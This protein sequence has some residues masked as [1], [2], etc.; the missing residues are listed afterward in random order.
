MP[1]LFHLEIELPNPG[2]VSLGGGARPYWYGGQFDVLERFL[3]QCPDT[4]FIGHA[5]GFWREM[6]GDSDVREIY[7]RGPVQP[8]G[9]LRDLLDRFPNLH[10]DL[11]A[12]S[13][14]NALSRDP[15]NARDFLTTYS[16][17]VLFGRDY[18]DDRLRPFLLGLDLPAKV[19]RAIFSGNALRLVPDV[20]TTATKAAS[21]A[22]DRPNLATRNP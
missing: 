8:G 16:E 10:C 14:F 18:W 9:R 6:S 12:E 20:A 15:D 17:R 2:G 1:V 7:P 11:S 22:A 4:M 13:G 5:P 21:G 3:R 19:Q